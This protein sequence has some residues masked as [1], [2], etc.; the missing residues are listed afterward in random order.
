[1]LNSYISYNNGSASLS[2]TWQHMLLPTQDWLMALQL[3]LR[4]KSDGGLLSMLPGCCQL[5]AYFW[6]AFA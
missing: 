4:R 5:S 1:M 3:V 2:K 6:K